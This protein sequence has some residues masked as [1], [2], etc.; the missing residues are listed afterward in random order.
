MTATRGNASVSAGWSLAANSG[1]AIDLYG[2]FAFDANGYT[3]QYATACPT[4]TSAAVTGLTNGH[5][6]MVAVYAH[7]AFGWGAPIMSSTVTPGTA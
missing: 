2:V 7:N 6:Y 1:S 4:C 5:Q 3:G